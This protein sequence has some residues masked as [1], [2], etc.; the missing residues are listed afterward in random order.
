M[1]KEALK[2]L[3]DQSRPS[4]VVS[5]GREYATL[6]LQ[7]ILAPVAET[8]TT[9]TLTGLR[10]Y[11]KSQIDG[12]D[13]PAKT[14]AHISDAGTVHILSA[15]KGDWRQRESVIMAQADTPDLSSFFG[16]WHNSE[17]FNIFVQAYFENTLDRES[18]LKVAG[19]VKQDASITIA[20][21]GTSQR[22]TARTG[23]ARVEE[24][25]LPN[26]V[27]LAPYCTFPEIDSPARKYVFRM[28][29]GP[30]FALFAADYD[31]RWRSK[32]MEDIKIWLS[33]EFPG[34]TI[35]A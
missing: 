10:D 15:L 23:V 34:M 9:T 21:D 32:C 25:Q 17:M 22:T 7:P 18:L 27:K 33:G 30:E 1:L 6:P 3:F 2:F 12:Q 35:L 13:T 31:G 26:P 14:M 4:T 24:I 29:G 20:D 19:N 8:I 28:R 5:G 11:L 16:R